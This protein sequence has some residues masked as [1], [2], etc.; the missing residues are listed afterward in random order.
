MRLRR[1]LA[2]VLAALLAVGSSALFAGT[3]SGP[4]AGRVTDPS[5]KPFSDYAAQLRDVSS[6]KLVASAPVDPSGAFIFKDVPVGKPYLLELV[7]AKNSAVLC[8]A[9]PY[10]VAPDPKQTPNVRLGCGRAPAAN[11]VLAAAAGTAGFVA[12]VTHSASQ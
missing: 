4:L 12:F 6:G 2:V 9:G 5:K 7:K 1:G 3:Q 8:T 11:W 10:A